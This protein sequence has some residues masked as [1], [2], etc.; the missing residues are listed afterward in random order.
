MTPFHNMAL[1]APGTT[2]SDIDLHTRVFRR[3]RGGARRLRLARDADSWRAATSN[4]VRRASGESGIA[5]MAAKPRNRRRSSGVPPL[6]GAHHEDA[7]HR[8]RRIPAR[9]FAQIVFPVPSRACGIVMS[10]WSYIE[11]AEAIALVRIESLDAHEL[12]ASASETGLVGAAREDRGGAPGAREIRRG[13][14]GHDI[15]RSRRGLRLRPHWEVGEVFVALL[16][17]RRRTSGTG[18]RSSSR[19]ATMSSYSSQLDENPDQVR[20]RF[21]HPQSREDLER[22]RRDSDEAYDAFEAWLANRWAMLPLPAAR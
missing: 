10:I 19:T 5:I 17:K 14:A 12:G 11:G 4:F 2:E 20:A 16:A 1:I 9:G 13:H 8:R 18:E 7:S 22:M 3:I 21:G 6:R 15:R